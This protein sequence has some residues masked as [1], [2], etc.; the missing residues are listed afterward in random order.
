MKN[1]HVPLALAL[2]VALALGQVGANRAEA[3]PASD[4]TTT[5]VV[6]P[7]EN[8][9]RIA[10]NH[11]LTTQALAAVNGIR[12]PPSCT[13][14][15]GQI[16]NIP[17][18]GR[19]VNSLTVEPGRK[20]QS[21]CPNGARRDGSCIDLDDQERNGQPFWGMT[22]CFRYVGGATNGGYQQMPDTACPSLGTSNLGSGGP[23]YQW[24][25][26]ASLW[27][28]AN[29][30]GKEMYATRVCDGA[31]C[32]YRPC[33]NVQLAGETV[34][35]NDPS[36]P[37]TSRANAC[38]AYDE[39][40][41]AMQLDLGSFSTQEELQMRL[42]QVWEEMK[43]H[44][45][46]VII[47]AS[48]AGVSYILATSPATVELLGHAILQAAGYLGAF[49]VAHPAVAISGLVLGGVALLIY[50]VVQQTRQ[51]DW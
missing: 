15:V 29:Y 49:I 27:N 21:T 48:V 43:S 14:R 2:I 23:V 9:F 20:A 4:G 46:E 40:V 28:N 35:L 24:V 13:I 6:Q 10:L 41:T 32:Y 25:R 33:R 30:A 34:V 37:P 18:S 47:L 45:K 51:R 17:S 50:A 19:S 1:W 42:N 7:G 22:G 26:A 5:H 39:A 44:P 11:G 3:A 31:W 8:L 16:L 36:H 38:R 12:C